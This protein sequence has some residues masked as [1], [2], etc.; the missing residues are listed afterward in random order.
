[1]AWGRTVG[2]ATAT[3]N[4]VV[5]WSGDPADL[6]SV[7]RRL[8]KSQVLLIRICGVKM[9]L[10]CCMDVTERSSCI[11]LTIRSVLGFIGLRL[12]I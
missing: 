10:I 6:G 11:F 8:C 7:F 4:E 3:A 12:H 1:M 5:L 9:L 2:R